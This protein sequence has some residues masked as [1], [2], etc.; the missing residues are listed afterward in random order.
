MNSL[1]QWLLAEESLRGRVRP[2]SKTPEPGHC[3]RGWRM[4]SSRSEGRQRSRGSCAQRR[5]GSDHVVAAAK[6]RCRRRHHSSEWPCSA[7]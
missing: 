3:H 1:E 2:V 4:S 7:V 5:E 6:Q